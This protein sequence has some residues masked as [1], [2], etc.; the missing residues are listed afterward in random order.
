YF[1]SEIKTILAGTNQKF[2][3][4]ADV[5][6]Q[7]LQQSILDAQN[8]TFFEGIEKFPA[9]HYQYLDLSDGLN[10]LPAVSYWNAVA[11]TDVLAGLTE[12][13]II[14][15]IRDTFFDAVRLCLR[16][17]VPVGVLL[18]GGVDSSAIAAAMNV[19]NGTTTERHS[20]SL[21]SNDPRF[22]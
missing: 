19:I 14:E 18:S 11:N 1:G 12:E 4:N 2:N 15:D 3:I 16:S 7:F 17:D 21:I 13:K 20:L 22:D 10:P 6:S 5:A 8:E 9:G